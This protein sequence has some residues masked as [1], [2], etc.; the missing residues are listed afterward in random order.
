[1]NDDIKLSLKYICKA[2]CQ[3]FKPYEEIGVTEA[4]G[5]DVRKGSLQIKKDPKS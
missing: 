4:L 5:L 1:M 3:P 2:K